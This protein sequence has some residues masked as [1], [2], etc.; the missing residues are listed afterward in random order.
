MSTVQQAIEVSA[1]LHTVYEQLA[2]FES[3]PRF[4]TGVEQVIQVSSNETHWIMDLD[5]QRREFDAQI[6]ECS[7]DERVAW[8]TMTGPRLAETITLRPVGET[9]TQVVA[10]LEADAAFLM[11]HDR[12]AQ[13]SLN[14]RLKQDLASLKRLI[15]HDHTASDRQLS[16]TGTIIGGGAGTKPARPAASPADV[17][18]RARRNRLAGLTAVDDTGGGAAAGMSAPGPGGIGDAVSTRRGLPAGTHMGTAAM[19]HQA[20]SA[21]DAWG[22]GMVNEEERGSAHDL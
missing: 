14:R 12:H 15:E 13:D 11:P 5:G 2:T 8:S 7:L 16:G 1:P 9:R 17:A 22:D 4:M 20:M 19:G 3:Y 21:D 6:I 10:Q 18:A